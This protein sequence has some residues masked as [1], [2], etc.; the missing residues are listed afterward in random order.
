MMSKKMSRSSYDRLCRE[1]DELK[2]K[3]TEIAEKLKVARS[4]GDL[5]E[6]AEYDEAMNEQAI[7]EAKIAEKQYDKDNA[8]IIEDADISVDEIGIGSKFQLKNLATGAVADFA[9]VDTSHV[10]IPNGHISE[11]SPIGSAAMKK[12]V[13]EEFIVEAPS[14]QI[15]FVVLAIS[16]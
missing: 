13:G 3:R 16:K 1:L 15:R 2:K 8:E 14:G 12:R 6:N 10:D 4:Y 11:E 9:I 7:L 5:S